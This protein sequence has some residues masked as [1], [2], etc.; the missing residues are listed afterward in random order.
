MEFPAPDITYTFDYHRVGYGYTRLVAVN[1]KYHG[2]PRATGTHATKLEKLQAIDPRVEDR[3]TDRAWLN[4]SEDWWE[5][6]RDR[7]IQTGVGTIGAEGRQ[8]G[9]L[10]LVDWPCSKIE[11]LV[12]EQGIRCA[13]C[14][15]D[16]DEHVEEQCLFGSTYWMPTPK[17]LRSNKQA[18][19][20][21]VAYIAEIENSMTSVAAN[22]QHA[23]EQCIDDEY[24]DVLS[25][26]LTEISNA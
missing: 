12:E 21:L 6:A 24:A 14:D 18:L 16:I 25:T 26:Q 2:Y 1:V 4:V 7:A 8:G 22:L 5:W 23:F 19:D 9:W 17:L 13:H 10:V 11:E 15:E 3:L 20:V